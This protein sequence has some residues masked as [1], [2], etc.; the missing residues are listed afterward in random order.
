M[1]EIFE[2]RPKSMLRRMLQGIFLLVFIAFIFGAKL[3]VR[4]CR[5]SNMAVL[6]RHDGR[7]DY[8]THL[9]VHPDYPRQGIG[10]SLVSRCL[11][12]LINIIH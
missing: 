3:R 6:C 11:Y 12:A 7:M 10:R 2:A 9:A 8:L 5:Q 4:G 1:D